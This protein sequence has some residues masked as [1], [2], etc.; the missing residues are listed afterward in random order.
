MGVSPINGDPSFWLIV[1]ELSPNKRKDTHRGTL[2]LETKRRIC[3]ASLFSEHP[4]QGGDSTTVNQMLRQIKFYIYTH[5]NC[6]NILTERFAK[7]MTV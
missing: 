3:L 4:N 2:E 6:K 5:I 1:S 7:N